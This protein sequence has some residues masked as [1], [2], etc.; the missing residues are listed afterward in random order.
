MKFEN[1][2]LPDLFTCTVAVV[3]LGYVGPPLAIELGKVQK[4]LCIDKTLKKRKNTE[5]FIFS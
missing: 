5:Y 3:G 2:K 1:Q 4:C